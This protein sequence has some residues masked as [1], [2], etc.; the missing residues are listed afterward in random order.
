[1]DAMKNQHMDSTDLTWLCKLARA[2]IREPD[3]ADDLV[4]DTLV[5]A[6]QSD[7]PGGS[8]RRSWLAAVARRLAS[9]SSAL[10]HVG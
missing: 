3:A 10:L 2:L 1:M 5:A 9:R 7:P 4:Q 6:L 8:A